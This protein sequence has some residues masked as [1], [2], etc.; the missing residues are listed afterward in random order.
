MNMKK[1]SIILLAGLVALS[2]SACN[3]TTTVQTQTSS[4][5]VETNAQI[6]TKESE[7]KATVVETIKEKLSAVE[8]TESKKLEE[9]TKETTKE[10]T[11][12]ET[13][14][15][16]TSETSLKS[17][18]NDKDF[19]V[20]KTYGFNADGY[21]N[22]SYDL[23]EKS[24]KD[25]GS[26]YSIK[27]IYSKPVQVPDN[28]KVGSTYTITIDELKGKKKTLTYKEKGL[29][30][31]ENGMEYYYDLDSADKNHRVTL[32]HDS[33]DRLDAPF[34]KGTLKI[35]KDAIMGEAIIQSYETVS[36]EELSNEDNWFN[37]V[38]FD[39]MGYVEKLVFFGD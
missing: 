3:K 1:N 29:L 12:F 23:D 31:D 22:L 7:T 24:L 17:N 26:Y 6:S 16:S 28:L 35:K 34:Y 20:I 18:V 11:I 13:I 5:A 38:A 37:G 39:D 36:E 9:T 10:T 8:T 30:V 32:Y 4:S 21:S 2:L 19:K 14:N 25:E 33:D 15:E 27:A